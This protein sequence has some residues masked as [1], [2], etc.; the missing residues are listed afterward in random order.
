MQTSQ[1]IIITIF[2]TKTTLRSSTTE[3]PEGGKWELGLTDIALGK[4]D[5]SRWDWDLVTGNGNKMSKVGMR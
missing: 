3:G 4:W 5:L 1:I 2:K